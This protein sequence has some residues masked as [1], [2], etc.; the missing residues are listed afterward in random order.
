M[1]TQ[2]NGSDIT[3]DNIKNRLEH[4]RDDT[5]P[6]L[7]KNIT[8]LINKYKELQNRLKKQTEDIQ[9]LNKDNERFTQAMIEKEKELLEKN[10]KYDKDIN[11]LF[12]YLTKRT[13]NRRDLKNENKDMK[14]FQESISNILDEKDKEILALYKDI[15]EL[16]TRQKMLENTRNATIDEMNKTASSIIEQLDHISGSIQAADGSSGGKMNTKK[17]LKSGRKH[18]KTRAKKRTLRRFK[19]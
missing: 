15:E 9:N 11:F 7:V 1:T 2:N 6:N 10:K 13:K 14:N 16:T 12:E 17:I 19:R 3:A 8:E 18:K 4:I 5:L